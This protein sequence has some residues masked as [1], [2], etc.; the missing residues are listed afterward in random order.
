ML[1]LSYDNILVGFP[2]HFACLV[3]QEVGVGV[4]GKQEQGVG[5]GAGEQEVGVG[6]WAGKQE[7]GIG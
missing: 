5:V 2:G 6:M 4:A 1:S 7:V 3:D